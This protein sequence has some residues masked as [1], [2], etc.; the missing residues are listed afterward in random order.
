MISYIQ[1]LRLPNSIIK[2]IPRIKYYNF[3]NL[4]RFHST[5]SKLPKLINL[6][7]NQIISSIWT[8]PN[9]LTISRISA[10]PFIGHYIITQN[11]T[12]ALCLFIYSCFTDF[13][14]GY[15]ARKYK[16]KSLVGTILD[17]MADKIL[18][19]VTTGALACP[20][21]PQLIPI[22][23]ASLII[24]RDALL[25][26]AAFYF[27]YASMRYTYGKVSWKSFWNFFH[28]PSA[29]VR[30]T[31]ISKCNTFLQM[32]YIGWGVVLILIRSDNEEEQN[33]SLIVDGFTYMGYLVGITT[34][35]SGASYMFNK[36]AVKFIKKIK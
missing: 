6:N 23:I 4:V 10:S 27:R 12:P 7:R 21:G 3:S 17:P 30:P 5:N 35:L 34:I 29:E 1:I 18:M 8:I 13:L 26:I 19:L 36:N 24:G 32:I 11:I 9:V 15:L 28:Y 14:D 16:M 20:P 2:D 22:S 33:E 31:N 25:G